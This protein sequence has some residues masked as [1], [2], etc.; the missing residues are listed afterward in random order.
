MATPT[1][2]RGQRSNS[3]TPCP[4]LCLCDSVIDKYLFCRLTERRCISLQT[5]TFKLLSAITVMQL[6]LL[7]TLLLTSISPIGNRNLRET[8]NNNYSFTLCFCH[9]LQLCLYA[10]RSILSVESNQNVES[11]KRKMWSP[12]LKNVESKIAF[13]QLIFRKIIK[14]VA[15]RCPIFKAKMHQN[16][17]F[18]WGS[19]PDP[20]GSLYSA[21]QTP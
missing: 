1:N 8:K 12:R 14:T 17:K 11:P 7:R 6:T 9:F 13:G 4:R 21:S 2:H 20:L 15:T 19:A 10:P 18:G 3:E 16:P 5:A